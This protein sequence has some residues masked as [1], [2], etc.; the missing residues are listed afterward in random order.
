M[1]TAAVEERFFVADVADEKH[2][3]VYWQKLI[4]VLEEEGGVCAKPLS[5]S[6]RNLVNEQE[7]ITGSSGA[8]LKIGW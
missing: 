4:D 6:F 5:R 3:I 7:S 2:E 1:I 8:M